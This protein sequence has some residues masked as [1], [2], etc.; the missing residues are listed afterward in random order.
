MR[1]NLKALMLHLLIV[2]LSFIFL[3]FFVATGP[4]IGQYTTHIISR[5]L[6]TI[7]FLFLYIYLGGWLDTSQNKKYDFFAGCLIAIVGII[8]WLYTVSIVGWELVDIPKESSSYWILMNVY[9]SPFI[10][11][12]HLLPLP[13][14]PILS[15]ALNF[16]PTIL[17]GFGLKYKRLKHL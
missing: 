11:I 5:I 4:A 10:I 13:N 3:I 16:A 6:I 15:L 1:N 14:T 7:G 2:I 9:H 17:M 8:I 12:N